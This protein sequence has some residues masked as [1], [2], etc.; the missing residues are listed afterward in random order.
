M[1]K[2]CRPKNQ[3][4]VNICLTCRGRT[5]SKS[6][7]SNFWY[8]SHFN[9]A[10][11]YGPRH[12]KWFPS[13][14]NGVILIV[15]KVASSMTDLISFSVCGNDQRPLSIFNL[16]KTKRFSTWEAKRLKKR[17]INVLGSST[18]LF[19]LPGQEL[20]LTQLNLFVESVRFTWSVLLVY[21][22]ATYLKGSCLLS[23]SRIPLIPLLIYILSQS[24]CGPV[25]PPLIEVKFKW[26]ICEYFLAWRL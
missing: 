19:Y 26:N 20:S 9:K 17:R 3:F 12:N 8:F 14:V 1:H 23:R 16:G 11:S 24:H 7:F 15:S 22:R 5:K 2:F 6:C 18:S 13:L 10:M 25:S 21:F 4:K